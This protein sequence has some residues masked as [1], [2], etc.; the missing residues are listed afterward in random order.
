MGPVP[1]SPELDMTGE[2]MALEGGEGEGFMHQRIAPQETAVIWATDV[3][4]QNY[5]DIFRFVIFC[6]AYIL[7][8]I[9]VDVE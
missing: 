9:K 4:V 5:M 3:N 6:P 1:L 7:F 2:G 8:L